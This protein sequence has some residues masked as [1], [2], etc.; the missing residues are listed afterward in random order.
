MGGVVTLSANCSAHHFCCRRHPSL[1]KN[2]NM[3]VCESNMGNLSEAEQIRY[4]EDRRERR[5]RDAAD[6]IKIFIDRSLQL[7]T[8]EISVKPWELVHASID[9]ELKLE[10]EGLRVI[11]A[12]LAGETVLGGSSWEGQGVVAADTLTVSIGTSVLKAHTDSVMSLAAL[13]EGEMIS[14]SNDKT[15]TM[16]TIAGQPRQTLTGHTH[17]VRAVAVLPSGEILSGSDD[18]SIILWSSEGEQV[19]VLRAHT[20]GVNSLAVLSN[21]NFASGGCDNNVILWTPEFQNTDTTDMSGIYGLAFQRQE[22]LGQNEPFRLLEGHV[23]AVYTVAA[24]PNS[25]IASGSAAGKLMVWSN[26]GKQLRELLGHT[27][28]VNCVVALPHDELASGSDDST[29]IIWTAYGEI[30]HTLRG[31]TDSVS[32]VLVLVG[33]E[34]VTG[35]SDSTVAI[36]ERDGEQQQQ[37]LR[38]HIGGVKA[39]SRQQGGLAIARGD[40][41][42]RMWSY[43]I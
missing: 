38:G 31:H 34:I 17:A 28:A 15:L 1:H 9:R 20:G 12:C 39:I 8:V 24:L 21:G 2:G 29:V 18:K 3:G 26:E 41:T 7:P 6:P 22:E 27:G 16:W 42:I 40:G 37:V 32:C 14:G 25:E 23:A 11:E 33:G 36:W 10:V 35:S 4:E 5:R 13:P 19:R 43:A 30:K